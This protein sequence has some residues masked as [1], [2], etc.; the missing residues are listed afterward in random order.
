[1]DADPQLPGEP[2][3]PSH[4]STDSED[5]VTPAAPG[6]GPELLAALHDVADL[7][8]AVPGAVHQLGTAQEDE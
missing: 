5:V 7:L 8:D 6:R 1:M 4:V 3:T 2:L